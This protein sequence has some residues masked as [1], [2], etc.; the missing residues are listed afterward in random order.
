MNIVEKLVEAR[1]KL[2]YFQKDAK[3]KHFGYMYVSGAS[4]L[5]KIQVLLNEQ[6]LL[7]YPVIDSHIIKSDTYEANGKRKKEYVYEGIGKMV[8]KDA[9]SEGIIE[10]PFFWTGCQDDPSKAFGSALTYSERY[11]LLKFFNIPTD[12]DD[13]DRFIKK[14]DT[15]NDSKD[16]TS[17]EKKP[18]IIT[19]PTEFE[20]RKAVSKKRLQKITSITH[21]KQV[22]KI[23]GEFS[24]TIDSYTNGTDHLN[25]FSHTEAQILTLLHL[26]ENKAVFNDDVLEHYR[27]EICTAKKAKLQSIYSTITAKKKGAANES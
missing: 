26:Y 6:N 9:E 20:K 14:H 23:C 7:L 5:A 18:E 19:Q 15:G 1:K 11:F 24:V 12:E 3:N 16:D 27:N 10:V 13:P 17:K 4:I 8:F 21:D 25:L 2:D 22:K